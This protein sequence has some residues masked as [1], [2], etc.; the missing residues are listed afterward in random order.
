MICISDDFKFG[1][2]K[3]RSYC[4]DLKNQVQLPTELAHQAIDK[5]NTELIS[6]KKK[7]K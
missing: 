6:V 2:N 4:F 7:I 5:Q 1:E 3:I